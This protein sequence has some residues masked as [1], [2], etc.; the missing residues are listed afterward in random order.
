MA[1][2]SVGSLFFNGGSGGR[3]GICHSVRGTDGHLCSISVI[4]DLPRG[5]ALRAELIDDV[6]CSPS[7]KRI[8]LSFTGGVLP[9]LA[10]LG[11]GFAGCGLLRVN[12]LSDVRSVGVCRLIMV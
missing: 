8:M 9:C 10:R 1:I 4:V 2:S 3:R 11:T 5:G 7:G 6:I 12:R